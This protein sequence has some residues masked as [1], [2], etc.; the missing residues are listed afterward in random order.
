MPRK[1]NSLYF[2][3]VQKATLRDFFAV[4]TGRT[5]RSITDITRYLQT[6]TSD[7]TY[8]VIRNLYNDSLDVERRRVRAE[9]ARIARRKPDGIA[10]SKLQDV[11]DEWIKNNKNVTNFQVRLRAMNGYEHTFTFNHRN[12]FESWFN[13]VI[14]GDEVKTSDNVTT[15]T[16]NPKIFEFVKV[17]S[18][19]PLAGGCNTRETS[20]Q[21]LKT[22]YYEFN[23][24]NPH[25]EHN[26]CFFECYKYLTGL[27]FKNITVRKQ[28]GLKYNV[29]LTIDDAMKVMDIF[30]KHIPIIE[31]T[32]D[33]ILDDG[34]Y[35]ILIGGKHY[36][37]VDSFKVLSQSLDKTKR[38]T[39]FFDF[40]T[41]ET[42]EFWRTQVAEKEGRTEKLHVIKDTI[43]CAVYTPFN[44]VEKRLILTSND[45]QTSARQ[46]IDFL[47]CETKNGRS[48][49][50]Y[51]HN[52]SKFD[53]Y[54]IL[55]EFNKLEMRSAELNMRGTSV[56]RIRYGKHIF[57]DTCCFLTDSLSN[58]SK[59]FKAEHGKITKMIIHG[60]E[61][62]SAELCFYRHSLKHTEFMQL[63]HTDTEFWDAYVNY[64]MYD[65]IALK[66]I[67]TKFSLSVENLL[68][69]IFPRMK[70]LAP[71][72]S[73]MTIGSHAKRI[74]DTINSNNGKP[75]NYKRV[76]EQFAG[77]DFVNV[78]GKLKIECDR[79]KYD[80]LCNFKRGG[81][82]HCNKPGKHV[83]GITGVDIASQYPASMMN[84]FLPCGKS[85][86]TTEYD[87]DA[88]GFYQLK[89]VTF[90]VSGFKPCALS[91]SGL[92][93][94]WGVDSMKN[95]HID[96]YT[97]KYLIQH[98]GIKFEVEQGLISYTEIES[99][100]LF[101]KFINA[102]YEQKKL[103]DEYKETKNVLYNEALRSTC[104]LYLNSL[105]GKLVENPSNHY[106]MKFTEVSKIVL[107]GVAVEKTFNDE[108]YNSWIVAGLMVYSYSKR[109]LFEYIHCLPNKHDSV[110]H[111]ETDGIYFDT[112]DLPTFEENLKNY[113]GEYP[114][115]KYGSE[116]GNLKVE[117]TTHAGEIAYF[118]G[119]KTYCITMKGENIY[120]CKGMPIKAIDINGVS[121]TLIDVDFYDGLYNGIPQQRS[122]S[123]L[124]KE[125]FKQKTRISA[126]EMSRTINPMESKYTEYV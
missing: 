37:V 123:A 30:E 39:L 114:C 60:K 46:F 69:T 45:K 112:R 57:K 73:A 91:E 38:G 47:N 14:D 52:G 104:K 51:A 106:S 80:F 63:Q 11:V 1:I 64:C 6:I 23:L 12:H 8:E 61:I 124:K 74:V 5:F 22:N 24:T 15:V 7:H 97:L 118:L 53:F 25:S 76:I 49:N 59:S 82:S 89:N 101:G 58:L 85:Q 70:G 122:W 98:Y 13:R 92:S 16:R 117:K 56:I 55:A 107:N 110:I 99:S 116:L 20:K 33:E 105:S 2:S 42:K 81:I 17:V 111:V 88:H 21:V 95:L 9:R 3:N 62:T 120:R 90:S 108:K 77:I 10:F 102:F 84:S 121:K 125:L 19:V 4:Q 68:E 50:I 29:P 87:A 115:V 40:E 86:W 78:D 119:K 126:F 109:L 36:K 75:R 35:I 79:K 34:K 26:D 103:Q 93:L 18:I 44:G 72:G 83:N 48:Y 54:F 67:W 96:S 41:R 31:E 113:T 100:K 71:L 27:Q 66:E 32:I 43:C 65:C 94:K 28:I